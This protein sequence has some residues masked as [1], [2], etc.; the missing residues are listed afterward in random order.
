MLKRV[1]GL[2]EDNLMVQSY[3]GMLSQGNAD[4]LRRKI[5]PRGR[6]TIGE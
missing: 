6:G 3:L 4:K 1:R 2:D 5:S